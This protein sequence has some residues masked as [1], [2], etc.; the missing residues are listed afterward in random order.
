ML[1]QDKIE[2]KQAAL[3]LLK[4][5]DDSLEYQTRDSIF[6]F[7]VKDHKTGKEKHIYLHE[8]Y[9][10]CRKSPNKRPE[11]LKNFLAKCIDDFLKAPVDQEFQQ[12]SNSL[13]PILHGSKDGLDEQ[14]IIQP[15]LTKTLYLTIGYKKDGQYVFLQKSQLDH[16]QMKWQYLVKVALDNS[17]EMLR[18]CQ[19][20]TMM[21]VDGFKFISFHSDRFDAVSSFVLLKDI[22]S[23]MNNSLGDIPIA[24]IPTRQSLY[25]FPRSA[26]TLLKQFR[27][28]AQNMFDSG[29]Y[30]VSPHFFV[31]MNGKLK[32]FIV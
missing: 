19:P 7:R 15:L 4:R 23:A 21:S 32:Q 6:A 28:D 14:N 3:R 27:T 2:L 29:S 30:A 20:Q 25:F 12:L 9:L 13:Y 8:I 17:K 10:E 31:I 24:S 18:T 26:I 1:E 11:I 5:I 16:W 22:W